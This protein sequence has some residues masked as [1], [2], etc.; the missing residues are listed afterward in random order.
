MSDDMS[1]NLI[2]DLQDVFNNYASLYRE[3][4]NN[5]E[6]T[7]MYMMIARNID[8]DIKPSNFYKLLTNLNNSEMEDIVNILPC[9]QNKIKHIYYNEICVRDSFVS[10]LRVLDI[11]KLIKIYNMFK[12]IVDIERLMNWLIT[13]NDPAFDRNWKSI[14]KQYRRKFVKKRQI[15]DAT[16]LKF[17]AFLVIVR[18]VFD[19]SYDNNLSIKGLQKQ[20]IGENNKSFLNVVN[21]I[22]DIYDKKGYLPN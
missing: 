20:I 2:N 18:N 7:E 19:G 4:V 3:N 5:S 8:K 22:V 12:L 6:I 13:S 1:G 16:I 15:S 10:V 17:T 21:K 11:H 9:L 14:S